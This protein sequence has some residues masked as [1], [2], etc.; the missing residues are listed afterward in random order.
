MMDQLYFDLAAA[1]V[2]CNITVLIIEPQKK[3]QPELL[4]KKV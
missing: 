4:D 3:S 1:A 2:I